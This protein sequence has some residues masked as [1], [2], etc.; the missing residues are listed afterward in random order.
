MASSA[1][2]RNTS[3]VITLPPRARHNRAFGLQYP[4]DMTFPRTKIQP[5]R[6]RVGAWVERAG[7]QAR[8]G[9]ALF[10][11]RLVLLCAAAGYGKTAA[12]A[13]QIEH[14]PPG[15][16]HAWVAADDGDDLHRLLGC[17][18][19]ALE[20]YDP[21][22]RIAPEAL[23]ALAASGDARQ[24]H[25]AA[26]ELLEALDACE[27]PHGIVVLDD[28]H[29]VDDPAVYE[30]IDLLLERLGP[31]WTIV[32]SSR[33]EPPLALA[34]HRARGE[35]AEFK[36]ADLQFN[37]DE[38]LSLATATGLDA[39]LA[40]RLW[41]RTAGWPVGLRLAL[42]AAREPGGALHRATID[43]HVFEFMATEVL[44]ELPAALRDF[45]LHTSVLPE[46]TAARTAAVTGLP[47]ATAAALLEEVER[48]GLFVSV[49]EVDDDSDDTPTLTLKLHDLFRDALE[50]R[51]Q[52]G[53]PQEVAAL[54]AR[55]AATEPDP[56]RR[57]GLLLR[58]GQLPEAAAVLMA[59]GPG[60]LAEGAVASVSRLVAQ[61]PAGWAIGSPELQ[62]MRGLAAWARWD[63]AEMLDAMRQAESACE[64]RG[65]LPGQQAAQAYQA[66]ALNAFGRMHEAGQRLTVLRREALTPEV[67]IVVLVACSWHALEVGALHRVGPVLDELMDLL[68]DDPRL[69]SWYQCMPL[70]RFNGLPGTARPLQ[71]YA[72]G[73]L[74]VA[75][76]MP[77]PLRASAMVQHGWRL[78]W[79]GRLAE[80][81][82]AWQR[83]RAD[84][85]WVGD[86]VNVRHHLQVLGALL[87]A[88]RGRA[89]EA[90]A[91]ARGWLEGNPTGASS[92]GRTQLLFQAARIAALVDDL[93]LL[94]DV[95][96]ELALQADRSRGGG[97]AALEGTR[98]QLPLRGHLARLQGRRAEAVARWQEALVCEEQIDLVGQ[99]AETRLHLAQALLEGGQPTL[100]AEVL[101][102]VFERVATEGEPGGV[103]LA[104][105]PL[106]VLAT[107]DWGG[108]LAPARQA[109]LRGW[110]ARVMPAGTVSAAMLAA[111]SVAGAT[112]P[113]LRHEQILLPATQPSRPLQPVV[114]SA[115]QPQPP[116]SL[117]AAEPALDR[118]G[119]SPREREVLERIAHGDSNKLIARA[120]D[121]SPHT[122]KRHVANLLDKLGVAS[123]GQA[124]AWYRQHLDR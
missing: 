25:V 9:P 114:P 76:D 118:H 78:L 106:A 101:A 20:P 27:V 22:W 84:A 5:P 52:R 59:A 113:G 107:A 3:T 65:D 46:L 56:T 67:R 47:Q 41:Q 120:F 51:L 121:L 14:L 103:L 15:T 50:H 99:A 39:A 24:R 100:A 90:A 80:A 28:M 17:L 72:D 55:A 57:I 102:P 45:L 104:R 48:R 26:A 79:Q 86:P 88:V 109:L 19:A 112:H 69:E 60:Q 98:L 36:Q 97:P 89:A 105:G 92:W 35:L 12:L 74:R 4:P 108:A 87:H 110:M 44:E 66:L 115:R 91:L 117:P 93:P 6:L 85:A 33:T 21:P 70:P 1:A 77:T 31:C 42:S 29:R 23:V 64:A 37:R 54:L 34:R 18:V 63:F 75:G 7:L 96:R 116:R 30:F 38:V 11:H 123:R 10:C 95:L 119:L 2:L 124:A 82:E 73:V 111:A 8:L 32:V 83:G 43:R 71:R 16:A 58:A 62:R 53:R 40:E 49:L 13:R 81:E 122:V 61:F 68:A 94:S